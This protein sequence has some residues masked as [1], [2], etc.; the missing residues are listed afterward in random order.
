M[1]KKLMSIFVTFAIILGLCPTG[2]FAKDSIQSKNKFCPYQEL[3]EIIPLVEGENLIIQGTN[4]PLFWEFANYDQAFMEI[5]NYEASML[6]SISTRANLETLNKN[7][8]KIYFEEFKNLYSPKDGENTNRDNLILNQ[9]FTVCENHE[10]NKEAKALY[11]QPNYDLVE[12][13]CS[14][15]YTSPIIDIV[16]DE[17]SK[18]PSTYYIPNLS[19]AINYAKKY[20]S[21]PNTDSYNYYSGADCTNFASQILKAGGKSTDS[22]WK[23]YTSKWINAHS[24]TLYWYMKNGAHNGYG[25]FNAVSANVRAGD[26]ISYDSDNDGRYNHVGFVVSTGSKTSA[27]YYDITI[28]QHTSNYCAKVSSSVN[29]WEKSSG[30]YVIL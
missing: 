14:L 7:N 23:P 27:G 20:A 28:A 18:T 6:S 9:F 11:S 21:S 4:N 2:V 29:N 16:S 17:L 10:I 5:I 8:W 15:P 12:L 24:F 30:L 13:A 3:S 22:Q 1:S 26:F 19:A 25:S